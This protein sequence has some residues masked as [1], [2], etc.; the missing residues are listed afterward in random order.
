MHTPTTKIRI[1][2]VDDHIL[3]RIGLCASLN[4]QA[5]MCVVGE[6][7]DGGAA[8]VSYREHRPDVVVMDLR[9]P[10]KGGLEAIAELRSEF[11][12]ARILV[13]SSFS[14]GDDINSAMQ[15]G[16]S[17]YVVKDMSLSQLLDSIR[18]V[19]SGE[20]VYLP[21]IARRLA[22]RQASKLSSRELEVLALV[23]RGRSNKE[24]ASDLGL[25]EGTVKL[26]V[27]SILQKLAVADRTQATLVAI[28]RGLVQI[29]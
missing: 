19:H 20:L 25:V 13:L 7:A 24:I 26:H 14:G 15:A 2:V 17:A 22:A 12:D 10:H 6:A 3:M 4:A 11:P 29:E 18:R 16:A 9:M 1:L 23:A 28:K 21:E 27:T 8:L 5:D